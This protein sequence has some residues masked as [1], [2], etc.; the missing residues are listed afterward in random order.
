[1]P[2]PAKSIWRRMGF[3]GLLTCIPM[4]PRSFMS[5]ETRKAWI[6]AS[7]LFSPPPA[8]LGHIPF[9]IQPVSLPPSAHLPALKDHVL[10][11]LLQKARVALRDIHNRR[12][13]AS[14]SSTQEDNRAEAIRLLDLEWEAAQKDLHPQGGSRCDGLPFHPDGSDLETL[15]R[16]AAQTT[17]DY[18]SAFLNWKLASKQ[19]N[20]RKRR[21]RINRACSNRSSRQERPSQPEPFLSRNIPQ[22]RGLESL[23]QGAQSRSRDRGGASNT[24]S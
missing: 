24:L 2:Y 21:Q 22:I 9:T 10:A 7:P 16:L 13:T 6:K 17:W 23:H 19:W 4:L 11:S 20:S 18:D 1:M 14:H 5:K 12:E 3:P 15:D 8:F